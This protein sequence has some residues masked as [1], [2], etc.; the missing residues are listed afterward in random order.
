MAMGLDPGDERGSPDPG[1]AASRLRQ[2]T[3][4]LALHL[5]AVLPGAAVTLLEGVAYAIVPVAA[6]ADGDERA[7]RLGREFLDRTGG[8]LPAVIGVGR[9]AASSTELPRSRADADRALRVLRTPASAP[10]RVARATDVEVEALL[11]DLRDLAEA[12]GR[13]PSGPL[14]RL[15]R[16]DAERGTR[17]VASLRAWLDAHGDVAAASAAIHVHENTFRY[18]LRRIAEIGGAD[19]TDSDTRFAAILQ[20]RIFDLS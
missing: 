14:A 7:A 20:L 16:Y 6:G 18:R 4:A 15:V 1:S 9:V 19:L 11:L 13:G 8:R 12:H 10:R 5:S 2:L 17:L 3:D